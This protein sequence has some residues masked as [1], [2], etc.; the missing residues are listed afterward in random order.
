MVDFIL[1][2]GYK[3]KQ[4]TIMQLINLLSKKKYNDQHYLKTIT[5]ET[6]LQRATT[7]CFSR[8]AYQQKRRYKTFKNIWAKKEK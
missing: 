6:E 5:T 3:N 2:K 7:F 1:P 8:Y 4:Q